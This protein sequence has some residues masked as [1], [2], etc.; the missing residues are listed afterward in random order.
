MLDCVIIG[1]GPAGLSAAIHLARFRRDVLVVDDGTSRAA[2]IPR[3]YNHPGF[4]GGIPGRLLLERM[5]RQVRDLGT[6]IAAEHAERLDPLPGGGFAIRAGAGRLARHV[7]LATGI[8]DRLPPIT[9]AKAAI[10]S[11]R[12]RLCPV[13]DAFELTGQ[14]IAVV[15]SDAHA[16]SEALFLAHYSPRI[17]LLTLGAPPL[18]PAGDQAAL[19]GQGIGVE[20]C[21][22]WALDM[23]GPGVTLR[24]EGHPPRQVAAIY[25]GLGMDAR[26][27]LAARLGAGRA[28]DGRLLTDPHQE[29][30]VPGLFAAGDVAPGLNQIATA[31][32]QGQIAASR[33]HALLRGAPVRPGGDI[34][35]G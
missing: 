8:T 22:D 12:L 28:E 2:L 4:P 31:M 17:T 3:T 23:G 13:C 32:A 16:A 35:G 30:S 10:L 14:P 29:T 5:R 21:A 25:S 15:G 33:I 20:P 24:R 18:W 27:D 11:G 34:K 9:D 26:A 1:G 6:A 7:I 19:T